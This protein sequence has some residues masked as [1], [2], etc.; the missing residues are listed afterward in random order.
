MPKSHFTAFDLF[1]QSKTNKWIKS[2]DFKTK[3][4]KLS[5][6]KRET[7]DRLANELN[8]LSTTKTKAAASP[9]P[10]EEKKK[11]QISGFAVYAKWR[12]R[13]WHEQ[14]CETGEPA[15]TA[16]TKELKALYAALPPEKRAK[17]EA[18][19]DNLNRQ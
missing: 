16:T 9:K 2:Q 17:C 11:R 18:E 15:P 6:K 14:Y 12:R 4:K 19:A 3:Y 1:V 10:T 8:S 5:Q 7:L 13:K